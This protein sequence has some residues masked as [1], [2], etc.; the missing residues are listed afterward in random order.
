MHVTMASSPSDVGQYVLTMLF[1][2][3]QDRVCHLKFVILG[4]STWIPTFIPIFRKLFGFGI[5][6]FEFESFIVRIGN[7]IQLALLAGTFICQ[8]K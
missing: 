7:I 4:I 1:G 2:G 5:F 6:K 8:F 3:Y